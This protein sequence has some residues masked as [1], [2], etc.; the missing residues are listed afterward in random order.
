MAS[1]ILTALR[2]FLRRRDVEGQLDEEVRFHL[3]METRKLV[4]RG[5]APQEARRRALVAFG[6]VDTR[7]KR[8]TPPARRSSRLSSR[9]SA[10]VRAACGETRSSHS[11]PS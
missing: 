6:G 1:R 8:A 10:T 3:D 4:E 11:P 7:K 9:T 2:A 5:L